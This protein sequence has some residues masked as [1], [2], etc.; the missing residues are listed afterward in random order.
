MSLRIEFRPHFAPPAPNALHRELGGIVVNAHAHPTRIGGQII[1]AIGC[2]FAQGRIDKVM[3]PDFFRHTLRLP[4]L[5]GVLEVAH[6]L[7][8]FGIHRNHWIARPLKIG[9]RLG[10]MTKLGVAILVLPPFSGLARRLQTVV[11]LAQEAADR[12][13]A[14]GMPLSMEFFS[15]PARA[16]AGPAQRRHRV[17]ARGRF[18]QCV[19]ISHQVSLFAGQFL[20]AT[21]DGTDSHMTVFLDRDNRHRCFQFRKAGIDRRARY[22]RRLGNPTHSSPPKTTRFRRCPKAHRR[23]IQPTGQRLIFGFY[24]R[25]VIHDEIIE[26]SS[27]CSSYYFSTTYLRSH[28]SARSGAERGRC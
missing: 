11:H 28:R 7:L 3:L 8:L 14:N 21:P 24:G 10:N 15:Q 1:N 22:A 19:E 5:A 17:P 25:D 20:A 12:A 4:F 9:H 23:F 6:R 18:D 26:E 16:F 13:L 27:K 2:H